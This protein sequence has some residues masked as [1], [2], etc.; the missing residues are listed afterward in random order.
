MVT[1][2]SKDPR[3]AA[4]SGVTIRPLRRRSIFRH[5]PVDIKSDRLQLE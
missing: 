5:E 4:L 1:G 3:G 2:R